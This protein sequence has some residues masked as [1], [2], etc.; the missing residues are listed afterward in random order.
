MRDMVSARD[1]GGPF[2]SLAA[3]AER[4]DPRL[5]NKLQLENLARAGAFDSL[6][7]NRARLVTGAETVLRRAQATAE[8]RVSSQIGLF[9]GSGTPD[10]L[11]LPDM[12]DWPEL[13]RLTQ[14]AEAIGFHLSAHPLDAYQGALKRLGV[15]GSAHLADRARAGATRM[16]VA[17]TVVNVKERNTRTGN[18]MAWVRLSDGAGGFEVTLFAEVLAR[19]RDLLTEGHAILVTAEAKMEGETLRLTA[20]EVEGMERAAAGV[21]Q[22][23]RI[24]LEAADAVTVIRDLLAR[25]G[26]GRGR[27]ILLPRLE[28]SQE[29][30]VVL[31]GLFNTGPR[32]AQA[33]KMLPG[34]GPVRVV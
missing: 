1:A 27:V 11:R 5:L 9:G 28:A 6:E 13:E 25:E 3:F 8:E 4:V 22:E 30:E 7:P 12:P 21:G 10:P 16:K 31:P 32:L 14:E 33:I 20:T 23:M 17:G 29:V 26:R 34:V 2:E 19:C 18:R 15:V 24:V